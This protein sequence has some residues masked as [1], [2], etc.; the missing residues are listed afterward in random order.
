MAYEYMM[1]M[2]AQ[3]WFF[4][5]AVV[6]AVVIALVLRDRGGSSAPQEPHETPYEVLRRRLANGDISAEEYEKRKV[7]LD[8]DTWQ[9]M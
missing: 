8:Q 2:H 5:I 9:A 7:I 3:W 4:W 1:G 6:I